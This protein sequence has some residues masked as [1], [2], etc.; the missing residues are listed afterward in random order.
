MT[1]AVLVKRADAQFRT[2]MVRSTPR[3][4]LHPSEEA[5]LE[6]HK[7]LLAEFEILAAAHAPKVTPAAKAIRP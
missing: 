5:V 3:I 4:D 1:S 6:Y 7:H 2:Q